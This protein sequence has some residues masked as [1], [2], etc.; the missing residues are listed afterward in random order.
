MSRGIIVNSPEVWMHFTLDAMCAQT[1][2]HKSLTA[3]VHVVLQ[4]ASK[5]MHRGMYIP[6]KSTDS[7]F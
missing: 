3:K 4:T 6:V 7:R 2:I 5:N 1:Q